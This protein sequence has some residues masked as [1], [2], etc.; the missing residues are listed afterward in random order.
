MCV[1]DAQCVSDTMM[2]VNKSVLLIIHLYAAFANNITQL[3]NYYHIRLDH[4]ILHIR[5]RD[6]MDQQLQGTQEEDLFH[7]T[8]MHLN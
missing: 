7:S 2:N 6:C 3:T 5:E 4:M 1:R 8:Q